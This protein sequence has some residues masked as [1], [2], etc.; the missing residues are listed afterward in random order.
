MATHTDEKLELLKRVPLLAGL[1]GREIE[2]HRHAQTRRRLPRQRAPRL[3]DDPHEQD[4]LDDQHR[5]KEPHHAEGNPPVE[6]LVPGHGTRPEE[7]AE[8]AKSAEKKTGFSAFFSACF[9]ISPVS[10]GRIARRR[11]TC[12]I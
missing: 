8:G 1:G 7:T 4:R 6:A 2:R 3:R 5:R 10:S 9:A 12:I 11:A